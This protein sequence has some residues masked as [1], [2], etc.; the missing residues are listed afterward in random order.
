MLLNVSSKILM[1][2][3]HNSYN[4]FPGISDFI[5]QKKTVVKIHDLKSKDI[6]NNHVAEDSILNFKKILVGKLRKYSVWKVIMHNLKL[7][8][9]CLRF[10]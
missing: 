6:N 10:T 4:D 3:Q 2:K 8:G 5:I 1:S 9:T 7:S